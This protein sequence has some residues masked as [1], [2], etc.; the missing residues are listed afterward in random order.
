[1]FALGRSRMA[2]AKVYE[3]VAA[4]AT[5]GID[6][7]TAFKSLATISDPGVRALGDE[8]LSTLLPWIDD[9]GFAGIQVFHDMIASFPI[10][11]G[12]VVPV[13]PTFVML[14]DGKLEPVFV[15]GW[16]NIPFSP[17]Q[18]RLLA[19]IIHEA[20]L[21]QEGFEGSDAT[22]IFV[23]RVGSKS[24]ER[25]VRAWK[26][27][28][29]YL[30]EDHELRAQDPRRAYR[31]RRSMLRSSSQCAPAGEISGHAV[32]ADPAGGWAEPG[33]GGRRRARTGPLTRRKYI[34]FENPHAG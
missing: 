13:K 32:V 29:Q 8:I 18:K 27:S 5:L 11:R 1:M 21:T 15:I 10:G 30:L 12:V 17:Y 9:E 23:P 20:I 31:A 28:E 3:I 24:R 34:P 14:R 26:V 33:G 25:Y 7:R 16:T 22:V 6:K 4:Y 19:T 2:L